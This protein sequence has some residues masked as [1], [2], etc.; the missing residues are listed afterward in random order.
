MRA[1]YS[2]CRQGIG[3]KHRTNLIVAP[4][5]AMRS[6]P[7][8]GEKIVTWWPAAVCTL[9]S[10]RILRS[11]APPYGEVTGWLPATQTCVILTVYRP[12]PRRDRGRIEHP[13]DVRTTPRR[14]CPR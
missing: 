14:T 1:R 3:V 6:F 7:G 5:N 2:P 8:P 10:S 13:H 9:D 12:R 11:T 4:S